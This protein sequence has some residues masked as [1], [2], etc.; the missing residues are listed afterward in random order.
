VPHKAVLL[1]PLWAGEEVS[2]WALRG[3]AARNRNDRAAA[4]E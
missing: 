2:R 1:L 4:A 3:G